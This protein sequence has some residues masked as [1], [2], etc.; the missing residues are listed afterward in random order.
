MGVILISTNEQW[1]WFIWALIIVAAAALFILVAAVCAQG[2]LFVIAIRWYR[3]HLVPS[4]SSAWHEGAKHFWGVLAINFL[5]KVT[6]SALLATVLL[7]LSLFS[8]GTTAGLFG[9]ILVV[10]AGIF[11]AL[12]IS[13]VT[14]Y[15]LGFTVVDEVPVVEAVWRGY[16]LFKHHVLVSLELSALLLL[17]NA[18][19]IA[20]VSFALILALIPTSLFTLAVGFTGYTSLLVVSVTLYLFVVCF[21]LGVIGAAYNTFTTA[22]WVYLFMKMHHEGLVSRL[23]HHTGKLFSKK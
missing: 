14:I 6:L 12:I 3:T 16:S 17:C 15:A 22:S 9:Q 18:V 13:T 1:F 5:E 4:L 8:P 23:L 19:V 7:S 10:A 20:V 21:L 11:L 2:A